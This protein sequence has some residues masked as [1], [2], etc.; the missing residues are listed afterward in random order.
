MLAAFW[1]FVVQ[2]SLLAAL[3]LVLGCLTASWAAGQWQ[4]RSRSRRPFRAYLSRAM[5][6][7]Y[8]RWRSTAVAAGRQT[9]FL[10][11]VPRCQ[12][13]LPWCEVSFVRRRWFRR[14]TWCV[15]PPQEA[16]VS[17]LKRTDERN[18]DDDHDRQHAACEPSTLNGRLLRFDPPLRVL[19]DVKARF[20]VVADVRG[21]GPYWLSFRA[22]TPSGHEG[23]SRPKV[24]V[25]RRLTRP[26]S[27]P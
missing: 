8:R 18:L 9:L 10:Q 14:R 22:P 1:S 13:D 24:I 7:G 5:N 12:V 6:A 17:L 3:T 27:L 19:A 15:V 2:N 4:A 11:L 23:F 26:D 21:R 16:R 20:E 25:A